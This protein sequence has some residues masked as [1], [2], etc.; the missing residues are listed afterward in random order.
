MDTFIEF[1]NI[2]EIRFTRLKNNI[3]SITIKSDVNKD[4]LC[5]K[6]SLFTAELCQINSTL[7]LKIEQEYI[8][9]N[10]HD[11]YFLKSEIVSIPLNIQVLMD[12]KL[13]KFFTIETKIGCNYCNQQNIET[14]KDAFSGADGIM[15]DG[16]KNYIV[17]EHYRNEIAMVEIEHCPKCGRKLT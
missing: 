5:H 17:I 7:D 15:F 12:K 16:N 10:I 2:D 6:N 11:N 8:D 4:D 14:Q 13:N 9:V 3:F 1:I